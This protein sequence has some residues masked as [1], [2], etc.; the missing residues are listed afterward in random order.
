MKISMPLRY[1]IILI[2][3]AASIALMVGYDVIA[4]EIVPGTLQEIAA[5]VSTLRD[6]SIAA[7]FVLLFFM[8]WTERKDQMKRE[9]AAL[10]SASRQMSDMLQ[11]EVESREKVAVAMT[12]LSESITNF[13]R[14]CVE[15][16]RNLQDE[17][18]RLKI[19][20]E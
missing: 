19:K 13:Q 11:A 1:K 9:K 14:N 4:A 3:G 7:L 8:W 5:T 17:V 12:R 6:I 15:I 18:S 16:Q 2:L 20:S 10:A